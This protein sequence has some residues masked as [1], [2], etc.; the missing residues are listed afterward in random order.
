[1]TGKCNF[2]CPYCVE[3]NSV[4][5][6]S[7]SEHIMNNAINY[8]VND[9]NKNRTGKIMV[10]L[11]GGEPLLVLKKYV[12]Q[13]KNLK[14]YLTGKHIETT[15]YIITN[16]SL[17]SREKIKL[18]KE[19]EVDKIR[20]TIDGLEESHDRSRPYKNNRGSFKKIINNLYNFK[21]LKEFSITIGL[22]ATRKNLPDAPALIDIL[23]KIRKK[24][25]NIEG[26]TIKPVMDH[27]DNKNRP[28]CSSTLEL[29]EDKKFTRQIRSALKYAL[30]CG[31]KIPPVVGVT[32]CS[33]FTDERDIIV[34][35]DGGLYSCPAAMGNEDFR[36]GDISESHH[37]TF[38]SNY[39]ETLLNDLDECRDCKYLSLCLGGCGYEAYTLTGDKNSR[40]C[41]KKVYEN[42]LADQVKFEYYRIK[43][44]KMN[45]AE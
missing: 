38:N 37:C 17:L 7:M 44:E 43:K 24:G 36:I 27:Y 33:M 35:P 19:I 32:F 20:I 6:G 25:V 29:M 28:G 30:D 16:G 22:N 18:L 5:L 39:Y 23:N 10:T 3:Q 21:G 9:V 4:P 41:A 8:L 15:F 31:F 34:A 2:A 11:F 26:I 40:F 1:L 13:L 42:N 14:A 45:S 12:K